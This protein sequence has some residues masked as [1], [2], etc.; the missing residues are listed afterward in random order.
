MYANRARR[1][2]TVQASIYAHTLNTVSS[3]YGTARVR[4]HRCGVRFKLVS[5]LCDGDGNLGDFVPAML[6]PPIYTVEKSKVE[7]YS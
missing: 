3:F 5:L 4:I 7:A 1:D 6:D 2:L